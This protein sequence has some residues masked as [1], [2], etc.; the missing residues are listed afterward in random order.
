MKSDL[1]V[2][3]STGSWKEP[4]VHEEGKAEGQTS[5]AGLKG[6]M[7]MEIFCG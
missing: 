7:L 4:P 1:L 2:A 3:N 5:Q 6:K